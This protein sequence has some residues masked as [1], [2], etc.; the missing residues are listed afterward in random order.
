[1]LE[2]VPES[3]PGQPSQV[4]IDFLKELTRVLKETGHIF[5]TIEN[6][7]GAGY[8]AGVPEEHT[9]M[10]FVSLLPR[11][12]ADWYSQWVRGR[13]VRTY[14]YSR[15]GYR[16]LLQAAG[17]GTVDFWGLLPS[18]RLMEKAVA[19]D[20]PRMIEEALTEATWKKRLRNSLVR[21]ILPSLVG[22][23]GILAGK[24][25]TRTFV[26][27]LVAHVDETYL[28]RKGLELLRYGQNSDGI[29]HIEAATPSERYQLELPLH[30]DAGRRLQ[31]AA[32]NIY[33]LESSVG[34]SLTGLH[35]PRP[36]TWAHY[37]GQS[38]LLQPEPSG[39]SLSHQLKTSEFDAL[40]PRVSQ[41]LARLWNAVRRP[42]GSWPD[43][44]RQKIRE[45]G[46]PMAKQYRQRGL[47]GCVE[48]DIQ[49]MADSATQFSATGEG[50]LCCI[51]GDFRPSNLLL[52]SDPPT[53]ISAV[54]NWGYF[55]MQSL[56]L[57]DLFHFMTARGPAKAWGA[58]VV[59]LFE[60]LRAE[61]ADTWVVRDC[62]QQLG[63]DKFLI[64]QF[65]TVYWIRQCLLRLQA[66]TPQLATVLQ[67]G[68]HKPLEYLRAA[69]AEK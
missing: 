45:Y 58:R 43:I 26:E 62:A 46:L 60:A 2:W 4:Q 66:D 6:R 50:F 53:E 40:L 21:P 37:R 54:L 64:P 11:R 12:L 52:K 23:F 10:R 1:M 55:E 9:R 25:R 13:P 24:R 51:H 67:E 3:R 29:V 15:S 5:I 31:A 16:S 63:V 8:F 30:P 35:V 61:S 14:T 41:Y 17:L 39:H 22:S 49:E 7:F 19:L 69:T 57:L 56:P 38:F 20:K 44:L 27:D 34:V 59:Q 18:Y 42:A 68:I 32:Q 65:L 33:R 48:K 47:P 36:I 28:S